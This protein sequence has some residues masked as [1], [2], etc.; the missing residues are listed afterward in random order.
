MLL[1]AA[2]RGRAELLRNAKTVHCDRGVKKHLF[3]I[4]CH[5]SNMQHFTLLFQL[6]HSVAWGFLLVQDQAKLIIVL[7]AKLRHW[8]PT[9][10]SE[11]FHFSLAVTSFQC[12][13]FIKLLKSK[14]CQNISGFTVRKRIYPVSFWEKPENTRKAYQIMVWKAKSLPWVFFE[15]HFSGVNFEFGSSAIASMVN[16]NA[17]P[18]TC[19]HLQ[20]PSW[21]RAVQ[22]SF[23]LL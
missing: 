11:A 2:H 13:V 12:S 8:P 14:E 22:Q 23:C 19:I 1:S 7:L 9:T 4:T 17:H 18:N 16:W 20:P 3:P 5:V 6:P 21:C 10:R 15:P